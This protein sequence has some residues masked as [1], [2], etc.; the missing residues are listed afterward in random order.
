VDEGVE[1]VSTTTDP[2]DPRLTHGADEAPVAQADAY[3]VLSE[4]ERAR[5]FVRPVRLQYLHEACG[6][7]T[8]MALAIAETYARNPQF[9][10]CT[11]GSVLTASSGGST[12]M[13]PTFSRHRRLAPDGRA[14][15]ARRDGRGDAMSVLDK[16]RR[17]AHSLDDSGDP[18]QTRAACRLYPPDMFLRPPQG[19]VATISRGRQA[20]RVCGACPVRV[21]CGRYGDDLDPSD[22]QDLILGGEVYSSHGQR[23]RHCR[24]CD[25]PTLSDT[26]SVWCEDHDWDSYEAAKKYV[27]RR[28]AP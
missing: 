12:R 20:L 23:M 9:Y 24:Q 5:G 25:R 7:V 21:E 1:A 18:W 3:L 14:H 13:A 28:V 26:R 16:A 27:T 4:E 2:G 10:G 6:R 17:S 11:G 8:T 15:P 22:R 19:T